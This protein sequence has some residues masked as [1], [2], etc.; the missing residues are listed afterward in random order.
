MRI[1][2]RTVVVALALCIGFSTTASAAPASVSTSPDSTWQTNGRVVAIEV[3]A[4]GTTYLGGSFTAVRP[5]GVCDGCPG[6]V[7]RNHLAAFDSSGNLITT[8]D[9]N[10]NGD[11]DALAISPLDGLIIAGGDF[12]TVN[13]AVARK[14]LAGFA[15]ATSGAATV[16]AWKRNADSTVRT[17]A[18]AGSRLYVGGKFTKIA[19][20]ARTRLAAFNMGVATLSLDPTWTPNADSTVATLA[21]A[22][23]ASGRVFAGGFF[24]TINSAPQPNFAALDGTTGAP[25][26]WIDHPP[27][28][29]LRIVA[30]PTWVYLGEGG[31]GGQVGGWKQSNGAFKWRIQT[32]G[33]VQGVTVIGH[34]VY[35]GGHFNNVC[36]GDGSGSGA[37]FVCTTSIPRDHV[38]SVD[39]S[40]AKTLG[41]NAASALTPWDPRANSILG[42]F[43]MTTDGTKL[44]V[45]GDF[46][47]IGGA[48][49]QGFARFR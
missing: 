40:A 17:L 31:T 19:G 7:T 16:A 44:Y 43:P 1:V 35:V 46:T 2:Q 12:T 14:R 13:G 18:V 8:W 36:A 27:F 32:D 29:I 38:F 39:G 30:T 5:F 10:L 4:D 33:D 21:T 45:G 42:V 22:R 28:Y 6:T 49:Q 48:N 3:A 23:D 20:H 25:T 47:V 26:V 41:A 34:Q 15:P 24:T 37:P 9:P 11:V